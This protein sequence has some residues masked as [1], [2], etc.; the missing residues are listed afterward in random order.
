LQEATRK[1][2]GLHLIEMSHIH[3]PEGGR[4]RL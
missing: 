4:Y 2:N 3:M 1:R